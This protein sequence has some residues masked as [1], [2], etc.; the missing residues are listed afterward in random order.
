MEPKKVFSRA[1]GIYSVNTSGA[2]QYGRPATSHYGDALLWGGTSGSN[3]AVKTF[4]KLDGDAP[5]AYLHPFL[6]T[7]S[8]N[9]TFV[10]GQLMKGYVFVADDT[11]LLK[12]YPFSTANS[13]AIGVT[14]QTA[15]FSLQTKFEISRIDLV[16]GEPLASGDSISVGVFKDEDTVVKSFGTASYAVDGAIRRKSLDASIYCED[17]LSL[18]LTYTAGSVKVKAIEVYGEPMEPKTE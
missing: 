9:I 7:A 17:Q 14:A 13:P 12:A 6:S 4:G 16:F 18:L 1:T 3:K 11:P 10:D 8:K 15:Y 2:L 5:T